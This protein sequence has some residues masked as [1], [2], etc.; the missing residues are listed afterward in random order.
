MASFYRIDPKDIPEY[1]NY[2]GV[3]ILPAMIFFFNAEHMKVDCGT[4]D[5]SKWIGA[6]VFK[7]DLIDLVETIYLGAIK[8]HHIVTCPIPAMRIPKYELLLG[9]V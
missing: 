6:F 4:P 9:D 3:S 2:F 1:A 8:G 7:Q 5:H